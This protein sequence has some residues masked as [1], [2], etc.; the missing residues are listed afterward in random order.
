MALSGLDRRKSVIEVARERKLAAEADL[1]KA[2]S[3]AQS[4]GKG[5]EQVL[6][7]QNLVKKNQLLSA[8][9][10]EWRV[11]VVDLSQIEIDPEVIRIIPQA[12]S[13]RHLAVPFAKEESILFI[14]MADPR[15]L[16]VTEDIQLRTGLEVKSYLAMPQDISGA[17]DLAFGK[18]ETAAL[19][20]LLAEVSKKRTAPGEELQAQEPQRLDIAEEDPS[21]PEVEQFVNAV[22]LGALSM[23]ASDIHIEP[24]QDPRGEASSVLVRYRVDGQ[25]VA[26]PLTIPWHFRHAVSTKIKIMTNSMNITERRIPQSGRIQILA[27]G[28]PIE[29]RVEIV[30]TVHGEACV[31]RILDRKAVQVDLKKMGF[32]PELFEQFAGLLKGIGGK[33]NFGLILICGPTGSGKSTTLYAALN[34]VNRPDIKI[35]TAE[36]PV[37]YN[38]DGIIQV[39]VNPDLKMRVGSEDKA[40]V[41]A[42]AMRS[43]LR[44]DP[45]VIMVGEIRD[46]ETAE[47]AMEAAMTGHLVFST[48]HT[49]DSAAAIPRLIEMGIQPYM[50][51]STIKAVMSQRLSR[52]LCESCKKPRPPTT[53]EVEV[54]RNNGVD[55]PASAQVYAAAG[56]DACKNLGFKGRVALHELLIMSDDL[57]HLCL[58]EVS[59]DAVR[60]EAVKEGLRLLVQDGL[61]KVLQGV[62]TVREVLGGVE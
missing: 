56:C 35:L 14:A 39:P 30:P 17:L 42:L 49:N 6:I 54:F 4:T 50:V 26:A 10:E 62:T 12:V 55:L 36:N 22:I 25:L 18:G 8:L 7:E 61:L 33:K 34:Y 1:E 52:R 24:H 23:K 51:A 58:R 20:R 38:V 28:N 16:F 45:D 44:L 5:L 13:R 27:Q 59:A 37:E 46:R 29:F 15:D 40:F 11:K 57:R 60:K 41:F 2:A 19:N 47:I 31:L 9:S 32:L 43:F 3:E 53:E 21:A 48:I